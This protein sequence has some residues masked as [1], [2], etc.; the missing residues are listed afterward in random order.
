MTTLCQETFVQC[1]FQR[2]L[3]VSARRLCRRRPDEFADQLKNRSVNGV[4]YVPQWLGGTI[5]TD[6]LIHKLESTSGIAVEP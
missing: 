5:R 3:A 2:Y 4:H 6:D 1:S